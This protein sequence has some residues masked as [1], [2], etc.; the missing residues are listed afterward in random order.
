MWIA[1][2]HCI[3][4]VTAQDSKIMYLI[5]ESVTRTLETESERGF[6]LADDSNIDFETFSNHA[7]FITAF[8]RFR[9][10]VADYKKYRGCILFLDPATSNTQLIEDICNDLEYPLEHETL[11]IP[12]CI[13]LAER[14]S[15][16]LK[17]MGLKER[18]PD[19]VITEAWTWATYDR[20]VRHL[21]ET[22]I[23]FLE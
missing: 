1:I 3:L 20:R 7:E 16:S 19:R 4:G 12:I 9:V 14:V 8:E 5:Q 21:K 11:T 10:N 23:E 18:Y 17:I 13:S 22:L 2:H 15:G 6:P